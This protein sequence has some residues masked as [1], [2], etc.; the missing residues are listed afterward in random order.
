MG[1]CE[2]CQRNRQ[3]ALAEACMAGDQRSCI[4]LQRLTA[5]DEYR[6]TSR[7]RSEH[8]RRAAKFF[9]GAARGIEA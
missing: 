3:R 2:Q 9:L 7:Y 5:F 6:V 1:C 8:H 4:E